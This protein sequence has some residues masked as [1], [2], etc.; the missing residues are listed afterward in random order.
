MSLKAS[1]EEMM[2][3]QLDQWSA[4]IDRLE[5][6]AELEQAEARVAHLERLHDL[7]AQRDAA[8]SKLA[9]L[10]AAGDDAWEDLKSGM[11]AAWKALG[12]GVHAAVERFR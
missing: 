6:R 8:R 4:E 10:R 1:Y 2:Q 9:A 7:R 11:D 5:A 3:E 12:D